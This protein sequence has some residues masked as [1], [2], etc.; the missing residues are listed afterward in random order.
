[1]REGAI[2]ELIELI[3]AQNKGLHALQYRVWAR[4]GKVPLHGVVQ[5]CARV[6]EADG[7]VIS[8]HRARQAQHSTRSSDG[9]LH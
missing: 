1:V 7:V 6:L 5:A 2:H 4:G 8:L 3:P 9:G